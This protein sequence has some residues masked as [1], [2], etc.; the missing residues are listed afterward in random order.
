[1]ADSIAVQMQ[2]ILNEYDQEVQETVNE[3]VDAASKSTVQTLRNTS[4]K[5]SGK[6]AR[7]WTRTKEGGG[8]V[9]SYIVHN[10]HY[11]LTH[12]LE[13]G[14]IVRNKKGTYGR[15]NGIKHIEPAEQAGA[16]EFESY[17]ERK[18]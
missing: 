16:Q 14:H 12:L 7:G 6:Y 3:A 2:K 5:K 10:K 17:I 15:T 8:R 9:V 13:N 4:P 18:L 11:Q 1:M